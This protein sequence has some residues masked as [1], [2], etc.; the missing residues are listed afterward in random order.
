MLYFDNT[1]TP[2]IDSTQAY[3]FVVRSHYQGQ[4]E[5]SCVLINDVWLKNCKLSLDFELKD[6]FID[7]PSGLS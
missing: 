6:I 1:V 2:R 4:S 7:L 3:A 5:G